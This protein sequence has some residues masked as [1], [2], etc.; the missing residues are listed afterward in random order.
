MREIFGSKASASKNPFLSDKL[1]DVRRII[2]KEFFRM[3][4]M[5]LFATSAIS[6]QQ[7][8][9]QQGAFQEKLICQSLIGGETAVSYQWYAG[10]SRFLDL[11]H[12]CGR[13]DEACG[14]LWQFSLFSFKPELKD[15][16]WS[17]KQEWTDSLSPLQLYCADLD[18]DGVDEVIT[19]YD[20]HVHGDTSK[21]AIYFYKNSKWSRV[22]FNSGRILSIGIKA[23][24]LQTPGEELVF[25]YAN[26]PDWDPDKEGPRP[27]EGIA[28]MDWVNDQAK[29]YLDNSQRW[30]INGIGWNKNNPDI[31][32]FLEGLADPDY[33]YRGSEIVYLIK[34]RYSAQGNKFTELYKTRA[35][36]PYLYNWFQGGIDE[37]SVAD[38]VVSV[39]RGYKLAR[40]ID[41]GSQLKQW[42]IQEIV[43]G[44]RGSTLWLDYDGDG[45]DEIIGFRRPDLEIW[46]QGMP[47]MFLYK[48]VEQ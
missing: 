11:S 48:E 22:N 15:T 14:E 41:T 36:N 44:A 20:Q 32:Y 40:Y 25:T 42:F 7:A 16:L 18:G 37:I 9:Y 24:V 13:V 4:L 3:P 26:D 29:L 35:F 10:G 45:K 6:A 33:D 30:G 39:L 43:S 17:Y 47:S 27:K 5:V 2:F 8:A 19:Q 1:R 23:D 12:A 46:E 34:Y 31:F 38:S 28:I 21:L